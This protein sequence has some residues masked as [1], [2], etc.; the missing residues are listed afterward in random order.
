MWVV[1]VLKCYGINCRFAVVKRREKEIELKQ[2]FWVR[3]S[4]E[5]WREME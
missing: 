1:I 5:F 2:G 3:M 4:E